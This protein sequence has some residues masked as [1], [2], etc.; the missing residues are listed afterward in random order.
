MRRRESGQAAAELALLLPVLLFI[1]LG[2][3]DLGRAFSAWVTLTNAV[4]EGARYGCLY[5]LDTGGIS[6]L[7][8]DEAAAGGLQRDDVDVTVSSET[9]GGAAKTVA[10]SYGFQLVS[11]F[12]FGDTTLPIRA[13]AQMAILP[14]G[15]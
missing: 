3:L 14:G 5:P 4:R 1:V 15:E 6:D 11:T 2:C 13:R 10:A 7:V 12:L 8:R 9:A